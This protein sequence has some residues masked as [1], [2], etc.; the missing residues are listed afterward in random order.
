[1]ITD[2]SVQNFKGLGDVVLK[3]MR[4]GTLI[5]GKNNS[6]KSSILEAV[7]LL[8]DC[9]SPEIFFKLNDLRARE[10]ISGTEDLWGR[11]FGNGGQQLRIVAQLDNDTLV[12]LMASHAPD[13]SAT[14][15]GGARLSSGTALSGNGAMS[16]VRRADTVFRYQFAFG[17]AQES[18]LYA[19]DAQ[20][21]RRLGRTTVNGQAGTIPVRFIPASRTNLVM[22][23]LLGE[24]ELRSKKPELIEALRIVDNTVEDL[25]TVTQ[26]TGTEVY[27]R[28]ALGLLPLAY[29]GDGLRSIAALVMQTMLQDPGSIVLIDEIENGIHYSL[30]GKVWEILNRTAASHGGQI[31]ATTHSYEFVWSAFEAARADHASDQFSLYRLDRNHRR[32][33]VRY[34]TEDTEAAL[35]YN[36]EIR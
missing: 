6:G 35:Q 27:I 16:G 14:Y 25:V 36:M 28:T 1:M 29:A 10:Q 21:V 20:G 4:R 12:E 19:G 5:V 2:L 9:T 3:D 34:S 32:H 13:D 22:S 31:I 8:M 24:V 26:P 33:V 23:V 30:Y 18:G 17:E 11:L 15:P 7:F